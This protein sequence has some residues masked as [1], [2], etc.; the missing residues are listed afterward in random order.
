MRSFVPLS[1]AALGAAVALA[2]P[3]SAAIERQAYSD[4]AFQAAQRAG[5][6]ILVEVH[7]PWCPV[8]AAQGREIDK[9]TA[10]A[11]RDL[12]IFRI[13]FDTQKP[14][15]Q[16]FGARKQSTIIAYRGARETGRISYI[17]D[18]ASVAK[19]LQSTKG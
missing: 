8:C 4:A 13:D 16:K 6:P 9:L 3:A 12:T 19:L 11:Y 1:L 5:K 18:E 7:A 14:L 2:S 15:W 10:N 17:A